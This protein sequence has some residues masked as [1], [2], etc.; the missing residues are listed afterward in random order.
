[1]HKQNCF[2]TLTI[3][4][5]KITFLKWLK[6]LEQGNTDGEKCARNDDGK[7]TLTVDNNKLKAWLSHC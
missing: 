1:M 4:V 3:T 5:T 7:L 2:P 6:R